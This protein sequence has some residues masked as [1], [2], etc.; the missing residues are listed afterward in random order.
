MSLCISDFG[1]FSFL[2]TIANILNGPATGNNHLCLR[3]KNIDQ[4]SY[5][6]VFRSTVAKLELPSLSRFEYMTNLSTHHP[7]FLDHWRLRNGTR[8]WF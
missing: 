7:L 8:G 3:K 5:A 1:R 2:T 4:V 6:R